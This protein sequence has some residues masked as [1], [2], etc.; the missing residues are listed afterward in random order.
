MGNK[1]LPIAHK[2]YLDSLTICVSNLDASIVEG[3]RDK[4]ITELS[5]IIEEMQRL[6]VEYAADTKDKSIT[7]TLGA[8]LGALHNETINPWGRS[9]AF[10]LEYDSLSLQDL[11]KANGVLK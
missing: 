11:L 10:G 5:K 9:Y 4:F 7:E 6:L 1:D 3:T 8:D 2:L